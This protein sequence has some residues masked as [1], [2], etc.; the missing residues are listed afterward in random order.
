[1]KV[2]HRQDTGRLSAETLRCEDTGSR[3]PIN[4][5]CCR[6]PHRQ[7]TGRLSAA[8]KRW[9]PTTTVPPMRTAPLGGASASQAVDGRGDLERGYRADSYLKVDAHTRAVRFLPP[10]LKTGK[11]KRK[12]TLR[13]RARERR[14][15]R[16]SD[17]GYGNHHQQLRKRL[18][19]LVASGA[20]R[21]ARCGK[22]IVPGEPWDL[23]HDDHD[24]SRYSGPEHARCN[25]ATSSRRRHSRKW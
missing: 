4:H 25:R 23:G 7:Y 14:R 22:P 5:P 12:R 1:M 10:T 20:V 16:P 13:D 2:G 3:P 11:R 18:T 19:P 9:Q 24:R 6:S 21:C 15:K 17:R 8:Q